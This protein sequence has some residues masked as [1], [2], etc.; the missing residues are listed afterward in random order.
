M[1][2][3]KNIILRSLK[4]LVTYKIYISDL[5]LKVFLNHFFFTIMTYVTLTLKVRN[6]I[7]KVLTK[8]RKCFN[9]DG[10]TFIPK[11]GLFY[12]RKTMSTHK[13]N[14]KCYFLQHF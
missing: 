14:Q 9:K 1:F 2:T 5:Y 13:Y 7:Q 6:K 12:F 3:L 4:V 10:K 8:L 11:Y